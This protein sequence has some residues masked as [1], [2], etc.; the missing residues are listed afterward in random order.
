MNYLRLLLI[1]LFT[2]FIS[3]TNEIETIKI[4][5]VGAL[6]FKLNDEIKKASSFRLSEG[7]SIIFYANEEDEAG[8]LFTRFT[9][10]GEGVNS[11]GQEWSLSYVFDVKPQ[12]DFR[13]IYT[14]PYNLQRGGLH[15]VSLIIRTSVNPPAYKLY[16]QCIGEAGTFIEITRQS[17]REELVA[18]IFSADL[19]FVQNPADVL[20]IRE[21][22]YKDVSYN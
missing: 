16:Q 12:S 11:E 7:S 10:T 4:D 2:P 13:G 3:C 15:E 22:S 8:T 9:L 19:C 20:L 21:G 1:M 5:R 6:E 18:G 17:A 14:N